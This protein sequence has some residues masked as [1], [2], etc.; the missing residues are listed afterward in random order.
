[1]FVKLTSYAGIGEQATT[2]VYVD[3]SIDD[4]MLVGKNEKK[5]FLTIFLQASYHK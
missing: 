4:P 1:M 5:M 2:K 3:Q